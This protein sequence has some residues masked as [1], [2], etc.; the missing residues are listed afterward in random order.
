MHGLPSSI[1]WA[2]VKC[3]R[4]MFYPCASKPS[5]DE[6]T[7]LFDAIY[8]V[9]ALHEDS[10]TYQIV[11][12]T[13]PR[14]RIELLHVPD[15]E[16][17]IS[18]KSSTS[19]GPSDPDSTPTSYPMNAIIPST[20]DRYPRTAA[21][22]RPAHGNPNRRDCRSVVIFSYPAIPQQQYVKPGFRSLLSGRI[23]KT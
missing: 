14:L 3:K 18:K 11:L 20:P 2:V 5:R 9:E 21:R 19:S 4:L 17:C 1:H 6:Q 8:P 22:Q 15:D 12:S 23:C 7:S 16:H 13:G 10:W